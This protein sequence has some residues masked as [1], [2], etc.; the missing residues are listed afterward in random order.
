[1]EI[2]RININLVVMRLK[3]VVKSIRSLVCTL[4][5]KENETK[6]RMTTSIQVK[7][8]KSENDVY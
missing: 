2:E 3:L 7:L 4:N 6:T 1:M 8:T 5:L